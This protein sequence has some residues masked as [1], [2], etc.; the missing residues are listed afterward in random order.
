M[1]NLQGKITLKVFHK[2]GNDMSYDMMAL[3]QMALVGYKTWKVLKNMCHWC[4]WTC[5]HDWRKESLS[6]KYWWFQ[7]GWPSSCI[8]YSEPPLWNV[9]ILWQAYWKSMMSRK[10]K[11]NINERWINTI[12]Q[13]HMIGVTTLKYE[14]AEPAFLSAVRSDSSWEYIK[15]CIDISDRCLG[16]LKANHCGWPWL[17]GYKWWLWV[18]QTTDAFIRSYSVGCWDL[19]YKHG[20]VGDSKFS[21]LP[22]RL[23]KLWGNRKKT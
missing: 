16:W 2:F 17:S 4:E 3:K 13:I 23:Q 9:S 18:I 21:H 7:R 1:V 6:R 19:G 10:T 8:S 11:E 12:K 22:G 5:K 20:V 15:R 14:Y